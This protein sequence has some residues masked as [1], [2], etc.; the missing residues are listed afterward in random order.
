MLNQ[1]PRDGGVGLV[2]HVGRRHLN[3]SVQHGPATNGFRV[4][5]SS[6]PP[7]C[8]LAKTVSR[9]PS[10]RRI[11]LSWRRPA[12]PAR[13]RPPPTSQPDRA[14]WPRHAAPPRPRLAT[15]ARRWPP[16]STDPAA[17]RRPSL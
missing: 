17:A 10:A 5:N 3:A 9:P 8:A 15:A 13:W 16:A 2:S 14:W 1:P 12:L 4:G 6:L 11:S 7:G